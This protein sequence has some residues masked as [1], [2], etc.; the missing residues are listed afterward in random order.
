MAPYC[1]D[2]VTNA[3]A[4]L[5]IGVCEDPASRLRGSSALIVLNLAVFGIMVASGILQTDPTIASLREQDGSVGPKTTNGEW[6]R[7]FP[8]R[9]C[10]RRLRTTVK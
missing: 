3:P 6:W 8:Y 4:D 2:A 10:T 1:S 9:V 5:R 7:M